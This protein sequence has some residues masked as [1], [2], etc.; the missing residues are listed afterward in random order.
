M[1]ARGAACQPRGVGLES[2]LDRVERVVNRRV[3]YRQRS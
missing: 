2:P 1:D 3:K